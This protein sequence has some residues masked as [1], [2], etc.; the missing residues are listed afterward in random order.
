MYAQ[1]PADPAKKEKGMVPMLKAIVG[2]AHL[3]EE[4]RPDKTFAAEFMDAHGL[5]LELQQERS[6]LTDKRYTHIG[7]GLAHDGTKVLIVEILTAK[8]FSVDRLNMAEDGGVY[9][10]GRILQENTGLY[11]ARVL[12]KDS[13]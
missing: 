4:D 1:L 7:I 5:L 6:Y 10:E 13:I 8:Y 2:F 3:E 12:T 9:V 11:A